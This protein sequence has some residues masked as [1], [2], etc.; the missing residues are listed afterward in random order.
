[1][2]TIVITIEYFRSSAA[3]NSDGEELPTGRGWAEI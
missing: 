1:M 3:H 2:A